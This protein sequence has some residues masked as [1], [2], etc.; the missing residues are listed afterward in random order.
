M[1]KIIIKLKIIF[2][3]KYRN[4]A[5]SICNVIYRIPKEIFRKGSTNDYYFIIKKLGKMFQGEFNCLEE[6]TEKDFLVTITKELKL[7]NKNGE[8]I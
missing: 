2:V 1:E 4:T 3:I 6:N 5:H 7:I 8:E